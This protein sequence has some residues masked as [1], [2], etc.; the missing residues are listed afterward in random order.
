VSARLLDGSEWLER[1]HCRAARGL[2]TSQ[3]APII[4]SLALIN[5]EC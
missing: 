1:K 2:E 3:A 4:P 5:G